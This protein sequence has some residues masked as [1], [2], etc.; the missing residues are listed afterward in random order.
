MRPRGHFKLGKVIKIQARTGYQTYDGGVSFKKKNGASAYSFL[1]YL[2]RDPR[3]ATLARASAPP[4]GTRLRSFDRPHAD[5]SVT[6]TSILGGVSVLKGAGWNGLDIR[7]A[8]G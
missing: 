6:F 7:P 2:A 1:G 8:G 3:V 5:R 4:Q